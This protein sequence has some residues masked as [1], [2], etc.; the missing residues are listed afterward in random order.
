MTEEAFVAPRPGDPRFAPLNLGKGSCMKACCPPGEGCNGPP[1]YQES[2]RLYLCRQSRRP[3]AA[4]ALRLWERFTE[5][6][7]ARASRAQRRS[8]RRAYQR[9]RDQAVPSGWTTSAA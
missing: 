8:L 2:C 9:A 3:E 5:A 4:R 6:R 1:G 7:L